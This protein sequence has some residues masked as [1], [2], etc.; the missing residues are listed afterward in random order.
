MSMDFGNREV[1]FHTSFQG[2]ADI[3]V[4]PITSRFMKS[5]QSQSKISVLLEALVPV[6]LRAEAEW[7]KRRPIDAPYFDVVTLLAPD[8]NRLSSI[9]A[10]LLNPEGTHAQGSKFLSIFLDKCGFPY[11]RKLH[12]VT[13]RRECCTI[14][15]KQVKR[16]IDIL[17]D[18]VEWGIGI[19]NKAWATEQ[20]RQLPDYAEDLHARYSGKFLLLRLA[21]NESEVKSL[22]VSA[23]AQLTKQG[24]FQTWRFAEEV[25]AWISACRDECLAPRVKCFLGELRHFIESEFGKAIDPRIAME[26]KHVRPELEQLLSKNVDNVRA[27]AAVAQLFPVVRQD[28]VNEIFQQVEKRLRAKL[29]SSWQF[30]WDNEGFIETAWASFNAWPTSWRDVY[31]L[32][33][34]SQP[35][36]GYIA[37]GILRDKEH[38]L[39]R[40]VEIHRQLKRL[41][42]G[43]K[44]GGPFWEAL[45][46]LPEPF[47]NWASAQ[48]TLALREKRSDLIDLLTSGFTRLAKAF[49]KPLTLRVRQIKAG[50]KRGY[51]TRFPRSFRRNDK[52]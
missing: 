1:A 13:V 48:G 52:S 47:R 28:W 15:I 31:R 19:E 33:L 18:G 37:L 21:G 24:R 41:G 40:D 25:D 50:N 22:P 14:F 17:I 20:K 45:S 43:E 3:K 26:H 5:K 9:L 29:G 11:G 39:D 42:W 30:E 34:E 27:A 46:P 16:R 7:S 49:E 12:R 8:E 51:R 4:L 23:Q 38:G 44:T 2:L 35:R 10:D 36:Y 32:R 6:T